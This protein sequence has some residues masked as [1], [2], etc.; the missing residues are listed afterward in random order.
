MR[1]NMFRRSSII[2]KEKSINRSILLGQPFQESKT[3]PLSPLS[4][5]MGHSSGDE[6]VVQEV[7]QKLS[8]TKSK[9]QVVVRNPLQEIIAARTFLVQIGEKNFRLESEI[10]SLKKLRSV[11]MTNYNVDY[12][13]DLE[14]FDQE[15]EQYASIT[16]WTDLPSGNGQKLVRLRVVAN[17]AMVNKSINADQIQNETGN[18]LIMCSENKADKTMRVGIH[19]INY[20]KM[21][22]SASDHYVPV[23]SFLG[24]T[25]GGKS[26]LICKF[27]PTKKSPSW[28]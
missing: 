14:Y 3:P 7:N 16:S 21:R 4:T 12:E 9:D 26:S 27:N 11:I 13:F 6:E 22:R 25:G 18:E 17:Q 15:F 19:P 1:K 10:K 28:R 5:S 24:P 2:D 20:T 23:I 8:L